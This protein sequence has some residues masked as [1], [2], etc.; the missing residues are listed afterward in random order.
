MLINEASSYLLVL[1][2]IFCLHLFIKKIISTMI[3]AK[4]TI[5]PADPPTIGPR[6]SGAAVWFA[7]AG[8]IVE[9][10]LQAQFGSAIDGDRE[11]KQ[12]QFDLG[13]ESSCSFGKKI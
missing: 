1:K 10:G 5:P 11:Q 6:A 3:P 13:E 8:K 7:G 12:T 9:A 4:T 2:S